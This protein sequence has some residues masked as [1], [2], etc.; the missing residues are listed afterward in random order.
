MYSLDAG[1]RL[2]M[3]IIY[4]VES[5]GSRKWAAFLSAEVSPALDAYK[6]Y[7]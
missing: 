2:M 6:P 4:T 5:I 7:E 1:F 3:A